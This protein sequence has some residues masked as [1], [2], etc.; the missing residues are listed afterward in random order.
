[1]GM[2]RM[3]PINPE[4][5]APTMP[6]DLTRGMMVITKPIIDIRVI[7]ETYFCFFKERNNG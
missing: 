4:A 5:P 7:K 6:Y 1:M 2:A 3:E